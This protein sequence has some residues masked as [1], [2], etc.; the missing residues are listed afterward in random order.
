MP[1]IVYPSTT[2]FGKVPRTLCIPLS[3]HAGSESARGPAGSALATFAMTGAESPVMQPSDLRTTIG[4]CAPWPTWS[5]QACSNVI[6]KPQRLAV[7]EHDVGWAP[8]FIRPHGHD[9]F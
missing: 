1:P 4:L 7:V 3:M 5:S 8:H 6:L 2:R 9:L